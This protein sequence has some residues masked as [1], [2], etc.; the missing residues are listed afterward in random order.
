MT[1]CFALSAA[2]TATFFNAQTAC[3]N[4]GGKLV[5]WQTASKQLDL[6][7]YFRATAQLTATDQYW[8][9]LYKG[10]L[11]WYWADKSSAGNGEVANGDSPAYAHW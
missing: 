10:S 1:S 5:S 7:T 9:G 4:L 6:E 11:Y 3:T 8:M 2:V